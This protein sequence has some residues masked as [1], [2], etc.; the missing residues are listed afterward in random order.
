VPR[1]PQV[2]LALRAAQVAR[3][4]FAE[5]PKALRQR[6]EALWEQADYS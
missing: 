4:L 6:I 5:R 2:E 3:R 1:G